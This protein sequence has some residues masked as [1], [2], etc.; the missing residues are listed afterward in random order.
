MSDGS[1]EE[2]SSRVVLADIQIGFKKLTRYGNLPRV[3]PQGEAV[4]T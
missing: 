3:W 2:L 4:T 1:A